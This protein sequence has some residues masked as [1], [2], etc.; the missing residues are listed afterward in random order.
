MKKRHLRTKSLRF[1]MIMLSFV[2]LF[3]LV[4]WQGDASAVGKGSLIVSSVYEDSARKTV[5]IS[6]EASS[7]EDMASGQLE[8][9]YDPQVGY[10]RSVEAGSAVSGS[11]STVNYE[12]AKDGIIKFA[13]IST[14]E[15]SSDGEL[16]NLEFYTTHEKGV[17]ATDLE[18]VATQVFDEDGEE[19]KVAL[20]DGYVK[21]FDGKIEVAEEVV[22]DKTWTVTFSTPML[23]SSI[24]NQSVYILNESRRNLVKADLS[25][26]ND[27]TVLTVTPDEELGRYFD[28]S[29]IVSENVRSMT[30]TRLKQ[31]VKVP[32][33]VK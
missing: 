10:A 21:P 3:A 15:L 17:K 23:S 24:T 9:R 32:F 22:G 6:V 5:S 8:L 25:L 2:L 13:W 33:T 28:Y 14:E 12:A 20:E 29:L 4:P 1:S 30:N 26:S 18:L 19:I 16:L 27:G 31:A 7:V 11:I